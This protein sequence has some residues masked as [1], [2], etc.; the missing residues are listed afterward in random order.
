MPSCI[1]V[2]HSS[3]SQDTTVNASFPILPWGNTGLVGFKHLSA[4][5]R[6]WHSWRGGRDEGEGVVS[7]SCGVHREGCRGLLYRI[8]VLSAVWEENRKCVLWGSMWAHWQFFT[9]TLQPWSL[10]RGLG[11]WEVL[12]GVEWFVGNCRLFP[13]VALALKHPLCMPKPVI[14]SKMLL[15][16]ILIGLFEN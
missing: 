4:I 12:W 10:L 11:L 16:W 1:L 2:H 7:A 14:R 15:W 13:S 8:T 5:G 9:E 3:P 6:W